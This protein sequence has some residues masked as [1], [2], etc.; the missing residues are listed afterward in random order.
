LKD[1]L[2]KIK[3]T[4]VLRRY[5]DFNIAEYFRKQGATIGENSR[6]MIRSGARSVPDKD[7]KPLFYFSRNSV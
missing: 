3:K 2:I 6:T 4:Y 5:N 7:R 1:S